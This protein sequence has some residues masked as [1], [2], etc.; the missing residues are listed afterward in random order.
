MKRPGNT[1]V[2]AQRIA[3][4]AGSRT[5]TAKVE[6]AQES[7]R[8]SSAVDPDLELPTHRTDLEA[9]ETEKS[10]RYRESSHLA[11][12]R[13]PRDDKATLSPAMLEEARL[14]APFSDNALKGLYA[15]FKALAK[16]REDGLTPK[17]D[18]P[19]STG[20]TELGD[21]PT[22]SATDSTTISTEQFMKQ[23]EF[24]NHPLKESITVSLGLEPHE[25]MDFFTYLKKMDVFNVLGSLEQK[26]QFMF[27]M[28]SGT[29][30]GASHITFDQ[31][32]TTLNKLTGK[33]LREEEINQIS[34]L[35]F[36]LVDADDDGRISYDEFCKLVGRTDIS[37]TIS[38]NHF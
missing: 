31:C 38:I 34:E 17:T 21:L 6:P 7:P 2:A 26:T 13:T 14:I 29:A 11:Q 19:D 16:V 35:I 28:F 22:M 18:R 25:T 5:T 3:A 8:P 30:N 23:H 20:D 24:I 1:V 27:T 9:E 33:R 15:R 37:S 10:P 36:E 12:Y 4:G 32:K